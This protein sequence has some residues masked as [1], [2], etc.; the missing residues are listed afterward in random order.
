MTF[1]QRIEDY[2]AGPEL[3]A[4]TIL[5]MTQA[6]L[7]AT[8]V[9]GRWSTRQVVA[10]IA[11][12]EPVYLDR[13]KR[14]LAEEQPTFFGGDPDLFDTRLAS[15]EREIEEELHLIRAV[16]RHMA[17]ILRAQDPRV[18][19]RTGNHSED[20]PVTLEALLAGI[21]AHIPHHVAFIHQKREILSR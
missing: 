4:Q 13:M 20:G 3:L 2:L 5:G 6:Q 8:P 15:H 19:E 21:T 16:R 11:D 1:E 10:H 17:R 14:I 18:L 7:D 9:A 12:F